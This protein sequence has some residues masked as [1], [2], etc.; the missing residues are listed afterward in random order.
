MLLREIKELLDRRWEVSISH[1]NK[2]LNADDLLDEV[3]ARHL[4]HQRDSKG[5]VR[6]FFSSSNPLAFRHKS[7]RKIRNIMFNDVAE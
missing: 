4:L 7:A 1:V 5:K 3:H 2:E 6:E